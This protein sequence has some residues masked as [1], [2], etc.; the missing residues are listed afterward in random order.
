[1]NIAKQI[2]GKKESTKETPGGTKGSKA[3]NIAEVATIL[4]LFQSLRLK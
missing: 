2:G 3:Q 1:L 4:N